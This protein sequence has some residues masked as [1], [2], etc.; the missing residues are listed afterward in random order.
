MPSAL[1]SVFGEAHPGHFRIGVGH[2]G[3]HARIEGALVPGDDFGGHLGLVRGLVGQ[4]RLADDVA[5]GE[6]MRHVGAHLL[7]HRDEAALADT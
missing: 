1:A 3:N 7:V 2:R 5:D 4:H 6:D